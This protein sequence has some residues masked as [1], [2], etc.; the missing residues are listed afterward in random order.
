M[1][2]RNFLHSVTG[3]ALAAGLTTSKA[4]YANDLSDMSMQGGPSD[5]RGIGPGATA[6]YFTEQRM[7]D[8]LGTKSLAT[9]TDVQV[10]AYN[11]PCW[12]PSPYME[13]LFGKGWTEYDLMK[14]V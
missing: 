2:R 14:N 3:A 5:V 11:F 10:I 6:E 12:H 8:A 7:L 13:K 9:P 1:N 4:V